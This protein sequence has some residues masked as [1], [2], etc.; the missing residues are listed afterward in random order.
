VSRVE[1]DESA[2][3][4]TIRATLRDVR[5]LPVEAALRRLHGLSRLVKERGETQDRRALIL[6]AYREL[7][8]R[9]DFVQT[10]SAEELERWVMGA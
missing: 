9:P 2:L 10:P 6:A 3:D 7:A 8:E 1:W 4:S 5:G